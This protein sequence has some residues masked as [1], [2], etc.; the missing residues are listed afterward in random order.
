[1]DEDSILEVVKRGYEAFG[2]LDL[3]TLETLIA[4]DV[5]WHFA[6]TYVGIPWATQVWNRR[7]QVLQA[8]KLLHESIEI[9]A[10]EIDEFIVSKENVL[11][12]GHEH[13][14]FKA[15]GRTVEARWVQI[16][17]VRDG[18]ICRYEEF[19]DNAAWDNAY[20]GAAS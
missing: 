7:E 10:F 1:M 3:A 2:K 4:E 8:V 14:R 5:E 17:T 15:T 19:A 6:P 12:L 11:V 20:R 9:L 18:K 16:F 13:V